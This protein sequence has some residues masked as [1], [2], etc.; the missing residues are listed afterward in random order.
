MTFTAAT[1]GTATISGPPGA[2]GL[3]G[4]V[5]GDQC[6]GSTATLALTITVNTAAAPASPRVHHLLTADRRSL[7]RDGD[8]RTHRRHHRIGSL[9]GLTFT[10]Q[11]TGTALLSGT[12]TASGTY[13]ITVTATNG[14]GTA[15]TQALSIIVGQ[16]PGI[17]QRSV[18]RIWPW[19]RARFTVTTS[20]YPP[21]RWVRP[22][23]CTRVT[24]TDNLNGTATIAGTPTGATQ[25]YPVTGLRPTNRHGEPE[26]HA[27]CRTGRL[28]AAG[29]TLG[30]GHHLPIQVASSA[31]PCRGTATW[32]STTRRNQP[33]W[34]SNTA[35]IPVRPR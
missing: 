30:V 31:S 26:L 7:R 16:K 5:V 3:P 12:P 22:A 6:S 13:P 29:G 25:S 33:I 10:D 20:G 24:F 4:D 21:L 35:A 9:D 1:N 23:R 8:G 32:S 17:H 19:V 28:V 11:G 14:I 2:A 18:G 15:A 34:A 27:L